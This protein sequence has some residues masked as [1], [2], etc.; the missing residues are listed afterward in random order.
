[1]GGYRIQTNNWFDS[2]GSSYFETPHKKV[3]VS[4]KH[5]IIILTVFITLAYNF[6]SIQND[7]S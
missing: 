7:P 6:C 2:S 3:L 1:M 4:I 5:S